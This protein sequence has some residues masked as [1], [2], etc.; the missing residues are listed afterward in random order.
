MQVSIILKNE[1]KWTGCEVHLD[2]DQRLSDMMNDGRV[3]LPISRN[4]VSSLNGRSSSKTY[5][6]AKDTIAHIVEEQR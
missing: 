6:V 1:T 4:Y 2:P 3:F 5:I